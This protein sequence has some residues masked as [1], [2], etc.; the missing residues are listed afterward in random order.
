MSRLRWP[1]HSGACLELI[2]ACTSHTGLN[3]LECF[4]GKTAAVAE[5]LGPR[6]RSA[7]LFQVGFKDLTVKISHKVFLLASV[8]FL[9][10]LTLRSAAFS[11]FFC[12][13]ALQHLLFSDRCRSA[14]PGT[15][16][17]TDLCGCS[18]AYFV[19]NALNLT[20]TNLPDTVHLALTH[21][22]LRWGCSSSSLVRRERGG[23][24]FF[25]HILRQRREETLD[26]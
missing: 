8:H 1:R 24:L 7:C 22:G 21:A 11:L 23:S 9:L 25:L 17:L 13:A 3:G 10:E 16:N 4:A 15:C 5:T 18:S 14:S 2:P 12:A 6:E 26:E 20:R 19:A